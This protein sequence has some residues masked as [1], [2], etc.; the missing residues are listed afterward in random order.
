MPIM[1]L[2][3]DTPADDE[4]MTMLKPVWFNTNWVE[5]ALELYEGIS[6]HAAELNTAGHGH[7]FG[8]VQHFSLDAAVLGIC[9]LFDHSNKKYS[10]DTIHEL[11]NYLKEH[12]T[13]TY[14]SR[15][16][17]KILIDLGL[18]D[19]AASQVAKAFREHT[20]LEQTKSN[21]IEIL[22]KLMPSDDQNPQKLS[23]KKLYDHRNKVVA[24][25]ERMT[26]V[27][28]DELNKLPSMD[29][30]EKINKWASDFCRLVACVLSPMSLLP[31][32]ISARTAALNVVAKVLDKNFNPSKSGSAY[33]EWEAFYRKP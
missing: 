20:N 33:Q 1:P 13:D 28:R 17:K 26:D 22:T 31:N 23:L 7:F 6:Q 9:K 12:F 18:D 19:A 29:E 10:K 30:M 27:L 14:V 15:L 24:H 3:S 21:L 25:Q 4:L 5:N 8:L 16:D 11:M 32:G 2:T